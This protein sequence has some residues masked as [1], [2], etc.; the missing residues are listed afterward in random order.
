MEKSS[1]IIWVSPISGSGKERFKDAMLLAL[2]GR[3]GHNLWNVGGL[4]AGK[5]KETYSPLKPLKGAQ[6]CQHFDY[7]TSDFQNRE[8]QICVVFSHYVCGNLL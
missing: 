4:G 5:C 6:P 7:R 3:R 2:E 1:W 8:I